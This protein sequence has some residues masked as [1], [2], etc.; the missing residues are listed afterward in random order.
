[1]DRNGVE[2]SRRS[3][4]NNRG[5]LK[6]E[7]ETR[8]W[9]VTL[10]EARG[11]STAQVSAASALFGLTVRTLEY[12][13]DI[14]WSWTAVGGP[15]PRPFPP[16]TTPSFAAEPR[17]SGGSVKEGGRMV[18]LHTLFRHDCLLLASF[19]ALSRPRKTFLYRLPKC[20]LA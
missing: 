6:R 19:I 2:A 12:G 17:G 16:A 4:E 8:G 9:A 1:M 10:Q 5:C 18:R 3:S 7:A 14:L 13:I 20:P 11:A 15:F